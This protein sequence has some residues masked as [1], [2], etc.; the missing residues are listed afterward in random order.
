M[1]AKNS[2]TL[3]KRMDALEKSV[4]DGWSNVFSGAGVAGRDKR[5]STRY[6]A[7][8]L[9]DDKTLSD[10]YRSEGIASR[11]VDLP[12]NDMV[13]EWFRVDGD[14]D[15]LIVK[16]LD[17]LH[18]RN[19]FVRALKWSRLFGGGLIV[20][21]IDDGQELMVEPLKEEAIK[22]IGFLHAFDRTQVQRKT[23]YTEQS[24]TKFGQTEIFYVTPVSGEPFEVHE[25]RVLQ[26][27]GVD[28]PR[29]GRM[30]RGG[31]GDSVLQRVFTRLR[32]L[33]DSYAGIETLITEFIIGVLTIDNLQDLI[34][35]GR[36][37]DVRKRLNLID[38]SKHVLN[39][40]LIDKEEEFKRISA[41]AAGLHQL[42]NKLEQALAAVT[43]IPVT[44]LMGT[45]PAGLKATGA[46]DVRF[47]YDSVAAQQ[48][49]KLRTP[50]ERLV[51][52]AQIA[53]EGPTKSKELEGWG[54]TFVPLWQPSEAEIIEMRAR[55]AETDERYIN[56]NVLLPEEVA[57]S[58]FGGDEYSVETHLSP[59]RQ[60][61]L[62]EGAGSESA[63]ED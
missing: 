31:W 28:I 37:E 58:R 26:F 11:V 25:T 50:S 17:D 41:S 62:E 10:L 21:G 32:G 45:S 56:T 44:L 55:Q 12:A 1:V 16:Y 51:Y 8:Q 4:A 60:K 18:V 13:R 54:V 34:A 22:S 30:E 53:K 14:T 40:V 47:Y 2:R 5:V 57:L 24:N 23:A 39:T 9:L 19:E 49:T 3:S 36:E 46:S 48:E 38:L 20:M 29:R 61:E 33:A 6:L 63:E 7:S 59:E 42:L 15:G 52:L 27:D 43:G 35:A